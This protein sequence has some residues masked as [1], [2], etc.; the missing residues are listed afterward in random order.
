MNPFDVKTVELSGANLIEASAGTGKTFSIAVLVVRLIIEKSIPVSKLLLVTFTEA[1]AAE[2]KE[3][4]IKFIREAIEEFENEGSSGNS[5]IGKI[6]KDFVGDRYEAK[7]NLYTA[8]LEID[9]AMMCTIHSF[10]QRTLNEFAFETNQAYGKELITDLSA[11]NTKY[12]QEFIREELSCLPVPILE[13]VLPIFHSLAG[14]IIDNQLAGKRYIKSTTDEIDIDICLIELNEYEAFKLNLIDEA[15]LNEM[16][17]VINNSNNGYVVKSRQSYLDKVSSIDNAIAAL[18]SNDPKTFNNLFP[19][20]SEQVLTRLEI[21]KTLKNQL[22]DWLIVNFINWISTKIETTLKKKNMFTYD[23]LINQLFEVRTNEKL[24]GILR[25]KYDVVFLDE[26]QD[27]DQKQYDIFYNLF[28]EDPN[29]VLFYIGDPKQS[30]YSWRKADLNTYYQA[31]NSINAQKRF[32]MKVNFRSSETLIQALNHFFDPTGEFDTFENGS[33][34]SEQNRINYI[35]VTSA[36]TSSIGLVKDNVEFPPIRVVNKHSNNDEIY[37]SI[38]L[39]LKNIFFGGF[40]LNNQPVKP[41]NVCVLTKTNKQSKAVKNILTKLSIPS[42]ISDDAKIID[43]PEANE[44][45][46]VLEA[47]LAPQKSTIQKAFLSYL[48]NY[49]VEE[50][51]GLD[52]DYYVERFSTYNKIWAKDGVYVAL[53]TFFADFSMI[54]KMQEKQIEGQRVISNI[55]QL[56]ELLQEKEL[57]NAFTPSETYTFLQNQINSSSDQE[58]S[59]YAQRLENDEDTVKIVTIHKSKGMEYD[60]VIA[61]FLDLDDNEKFEFSSIRLPRDEAGNNYVYVTNPITDQNLKQYYSIQQKQENRRL[62]YVALTRAKYNLIII[63]KTKNNKHSLAGFIKALPGD[64]NTIEVINREDLERG[65]KGNLEKGLK[66]TQVMKNPLP[67]ITFA[68]SQYKKMSYSFLAAHPTKGFKEQIVEYA[69]GTYDQFVFKD[70]PKGA[71][72][73]NLLHDIFEYIDYS[74]SSKWMD[75]I[76][77]VII[78]YLPSQKHN[79]SFSESLLKLIEHTLQAKIKFGD[80]SFQLATLTRER[81]KNEFEFNFAIPTKFEV[82]ELETILKD[83]VRVIKNNYSEVQGMMTGFIDLFFEHD[84]KYYILDWKSNFLGDAI[85]DY[86]SSK[87]TQAMNESNYHLQYLIYAL[88]LDKYLTS[89]LPSFDFEQQ[90][91]GVVYL[92]LRGN[93]AGEQTGVYTQTV[94]KEELIRLK[95]VLKIF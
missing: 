19:E 48:L 8:L 87:L 18:E 58:V 27:T 10:C 31:R 93:R 60:V 24:K 75:I 6:V 53:N 45:L 72:V 17:E 39:T 35:P 21:I 43:S 22:Q 26:F 66:N 91:G 13:I 38:E 56:V 90:F 25:E 16:R 86:H 74:D 29:K 85:E 83:D 36:N 28:Q 71:H 68:D 94:T 59:E 73:G 41:S 11:I 47:M 54:Q 55:K 77:N 32:D 52:F 81:R 37:E 50:I 63:N 12:K 2:L 57:R 20:L 46:Y 67:S 44:L 92:F 95:K 30:I 7:E 89:K 88:A 33:E 40:T 84:G 9:Q 42:V 62:I 65:A 3:R 49:K 79:P 61:P 15:Q 51:K 64:T 70:L 80:K 34:A 82:S 76:Q 5:M 1:A 69:L 4:S 14:K 78:R 23:D